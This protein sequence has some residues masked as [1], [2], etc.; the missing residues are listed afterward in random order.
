MSRSN[1]SVE[2]ES[3]WRGLHESYR[4]SGLTVRAFCQ[5]E[6]VSEPSFYSWRKELG[7]RDASRG[8][9][10]HRPNLIPVDIVDSAGD[11]SG[12][13]DSGRGNETSASP[14]LEVVMPCGFT[15]RFHHDIEPQRLS[16]ILSVL[17]QHTRCNGVL[18]C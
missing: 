8:R 15:L 1:R 7:K 11:N 10:V 12:H 16:A 14:L 3:F 18:P 17:E 5:R 13:G 9:A 4:G 6:G 2:K